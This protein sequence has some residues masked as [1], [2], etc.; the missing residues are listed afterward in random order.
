ML[1]VTVRLDGKAPISAAT[2]RIPRFCRASALTL[3]PG[4]V[5]GA[6]SA[7]LGIVFIPIDESELGLS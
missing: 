7:Y 5:S 1:P 3:T 6:A 4:P 2:T